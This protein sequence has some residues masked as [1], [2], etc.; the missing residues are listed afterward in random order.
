[1]H[2][3]DPDHREA[4]DALSRIKELRAQLEDEIA[5][6][7]EVRRTAEEL[8]REAERLRDAIGRLP[9]EQPE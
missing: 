2:F 1:M 6:S 8:A 9:P 4:L 5:H 3:A 7:R